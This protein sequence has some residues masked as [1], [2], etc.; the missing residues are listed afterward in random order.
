MLKS[1]Q[2]RNFTVFPSAHFDF[3]PGIN[4]F[5]G[6]N[7]TGKTHLLK[8]AY[9]LDRAWSD[10]T[11]KPGSISKKHAEVYFEERLLSLFQIKELTYL[12]R[13]AK[14]E[15]LSDTEILLGLEAKIYPF[16]PTTDSN[17]NGISNSSA[18]MPI[19]S[20]IESTDWKLFLLYV[21]YK[22]N[23]VGVCG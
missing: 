20:C 9:C 16:I 5:V 6:E 4:A 12:I 19:N 15:S 22:G 21:N 18:K 23:K 7:G 13:R 3:S 17:L 14:G 11:R 10:L 8:V 2:L 1:L